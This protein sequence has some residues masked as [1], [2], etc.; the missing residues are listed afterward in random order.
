[1][2]YLQAVAGG[3]ASGTTR[4]RVFD[5]DSGES[6]TLTE[7]ERAFAG[8]GVFWFETGIVL[9]TQPEFEETQGTLQVFNPD[10]IL[11]NEITLDGENALVHENPM[12]VDGKY[13]LAFEAGTMYRLLD[14][15]TGVYTSVEGNAARISA[16]VPDDSLR[17]YAH[18]TTDKFTV[19]EVYRPEG[20]VALDIAE[21]YGFSISPDGQSVSYVSPPTLDQVMFWD[22]SLFLLLA[23]NSGVDADYTVWGPTVYTVSTAV[24]DWRPAQG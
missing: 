23:P 21:G 17:L 6:R 15:A 9:Y 2:A 11:I 24:G 13:W 16:L 4:L 10:G 3:S 1:L 19:W 5:L 8:Y 12:L 18:T 20:G 14:L 7:I 22:G